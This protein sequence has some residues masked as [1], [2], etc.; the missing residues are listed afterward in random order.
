MIDD[1][2]DTSASTGHS[3]ID[4]SRRKRRQKLLIPSGKSERVLYLND[5]ARRLVPGVEF[6]ALSLA[7]GL[8]IA[9]GIL[10]D[11]PAMLVLGALLAPFM[12]PVVGLAFSTVIGSIP[13]FLRSTG[14]LIIG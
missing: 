13:F 3:H 10:L 9:I 7:A 11:S 4:E 8:V 5:I 1:P 12:S 14:A 2:Q 6:F